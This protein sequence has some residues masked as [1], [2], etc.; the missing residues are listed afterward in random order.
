MLRNLIIL[1]L[2]PVLAGCL[3]SGPGTAIRGKV[4]FERLPAA[5]VE[6]EAYRADTIHL[7]AQPDFRSAVTGA[8]GMF[9][10]ALPPGSYY[11][12]ARGA[13]LFSYY[14]R[15]PVLVPAAGL[16]EV[17]LGLVQ[18]PDKKD[19]DATQ[20]FVIGQVTHAGQPQAD[21]IVFIYTDLTT[22]LKGLGY[23]M[24]GPTDEQGQF[25]LDLPDG[26][27]YLIARKRQGN[28]TVGP[29]RAG[30]FVGYYPHNPLRVR[31]NRAE[32]VIIPMLEVPDKVEQMNMNFNGQTSI[33]GLITNSAG[34]PVDGVR[35]VLYVRPQMLDRPLLV[36]Q[37]T[38]ADG[39]YTLSM[40]KGGDYYLAARNTLGGAPGPGD[41]YGTYDEN[42]N[43]ML[44]I[45]SGAVQDGIDITVEEMW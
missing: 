45:D 24:A 21:A 29:L 6:V 31:D 5:G 3:A 15:N 11:L 10:I 32:P 22:Q 4:N 1:L 37:P 40:P 42:P 12:L 33:S 17:S 28:M 2:L 14:G 27:Y 9:L 34:E 26:T 16:D 8:D 7:P 36:S 44:H 43:H 30:D 25:E 13:G 19:S 35:V 39:R 41:L 20:Q 23:M 38:G 18:Q